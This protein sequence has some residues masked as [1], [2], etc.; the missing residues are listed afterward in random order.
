MDSPRIPIRNLY[1]LLCYSWDQLPQGELVD[2]SRITGTELADLFAHVLCDGVAHLAR[3][4][5]E[6]G[7]ERREAELK[8]VRGRIDLLQSARRFLPA[9]GLALCR[10]DEISANTLANQIIKATLLQL[11][12]TR[13]L[14]RDLQKR[15]AALH[16]G[17]QGVAEI[18][19]TSHAFRRV[20]LHAN[21]RFYRFLLNVCELVHSAGLVDQSTGDYRFRDFVRDEQRMAMV[22]QNF[23]YNFIRREVPGWQVRRENIQWDA[24][25]STDPLLSLLPQMQTDITL[26]RGTEHKIID[27]KY[28]Q[29]TLAE[30]YGTS[31]VHSDNLFQLFSYLANGSKKR[32]ADEQLSGMLIYPRV[33]RTVR[34]AYTLQGRFPIMVATVDLEQDWK[35]LREEIIQ[36]IG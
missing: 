19:L 28:Y 17:L 10:F 15:V 32:G 18:R 30:R 29:K 14:D 34:A 36:L 8:G 9:H 27:A 3:R 4:G 26:C 13:G 21:N 11:K 6:Q 35:A 25:S 22:F 2:V 24:E 16:R 5:L 33:D 7:Y 31:K 20:H 23:L 12:R 1:Y